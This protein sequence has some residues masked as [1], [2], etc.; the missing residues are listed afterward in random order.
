MDIHEGMTI[1]EVG[2]G[3]G[4]Y[5]FEAARC[6]GA[7][8]HVHAVDIEPKVIAVLDQRIE[9]A[10]VKNITTRVASA[11][12][13]PLPDNSVDRA[14]MVGVLPQIPDKH[15]ALGEI[16]RVLKKQGLLALAEVLIDPDYPFRKTEIG[17]CTDTGLELV[18]DY[19]SFFFYTLTFRSTDEPLPEEEL[20]RRGTHAVASTD[21]W[22]SLFLLPQRGVAGALSSGDQ[23]IIILA[24]SA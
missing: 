23:C 8:G 21:I 6:A 3:T 15:R 5:T 11:Y 2:P 7:S 9:E 22:A 20:R 18:G 4:F 1:L 12:E 13:I 10:G 24:V 16:R 17:W 19:G 14:L